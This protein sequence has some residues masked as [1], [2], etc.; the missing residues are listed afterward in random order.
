MGLFDSLQTALESLGHNK[1]RSFL[2]TLGVIV[3]VASVI[4]MVALGTGATEAVKGQF[5]GLVPTN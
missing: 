2:T 1:L 3:G 4:V 5:R